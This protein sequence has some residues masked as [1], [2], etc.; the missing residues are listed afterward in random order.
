MEVL[1]PKKKIDDEQDFKVEKNEDGNKEL[2]ER[3]LTRVK[4]YIDDTETDLHEEDMD[5]DE[6]KIELWFHKIK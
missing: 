3:K 4:K 1:S 5:A 6:P 2:I